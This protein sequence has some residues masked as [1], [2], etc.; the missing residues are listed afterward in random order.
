MTGCAVIRNNLQMD[1][2]LTPGAKKS[3]CCYQVDYF[4]I[5][6]LNEVVSAS[7]PPYFGTQQEVAACAS[8]FCKR[9]AHGL[10]YNHLPVNVE[11]T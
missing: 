9:L 10:L 6:G 1:D 4:S 3:Y 8:S 11:S 7:S 2:V 5:T